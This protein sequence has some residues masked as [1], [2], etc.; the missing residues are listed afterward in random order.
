[1]VQL[2]SLGFLSY[3]Q[4]HVGPIQ[5]FF[6]ATPQR[7]IL[8][9]C[10]WDMVRGPVLTFKIDQLPTDAPYHQDERRFGLLATTEDLLDTW[11]P[12]GFIVHRHLSENPRAISISGGVIYAPRENA[13]KFHWS[14][15]ANIEHMPLAH[16]NPRS[17]ICVG[18]LVAVNP[19]CNV[20]EQECWETSMDPFQR[21]TMTVGV[22]RACGCAHKI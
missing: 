15:T 16:L 10:I 12:G 22:C 19:N 4:A 13:S 7:I 5:P 17:K 9:T 21:E 1:M 11:G 18:S 2:I 8:L 14:P 3:N 6:L 20:N